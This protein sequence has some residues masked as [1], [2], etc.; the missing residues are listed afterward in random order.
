MD[1]RV[2]IVVGLSKS[3]APGGTVGYP[4]MSAPNGASERKKKSRSCLLD[5][6]RDSLRLAGR[7]ETR[8]TGPDRRCTCVLDISGEAGGAVVLADGGG[9]RAIG[10]IASSCTECDHSA[11]GGQFSGDN[12]R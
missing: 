3:G 12:H 1:P 5:E 4:A 11:A 10:H 2:A 9:V 6:H 7:H 8:S